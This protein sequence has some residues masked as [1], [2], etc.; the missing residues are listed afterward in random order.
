MKNGRDPSAH[1]DENV[2]SLAQARKKASKGLKRSA[3]P[4][5]RG[6]PRPTAGQWLTSAFFVV[7][8]IGGGFALAVPLLRAAGL[9]GG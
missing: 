8:A 7:L 3:A 2:V 5:D 9:V 6:E 1:E 4:P